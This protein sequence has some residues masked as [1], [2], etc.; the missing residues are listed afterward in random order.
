M[1][2]RKGE[3]GKLIIDRARKLGFETVAHN[4]SR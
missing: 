3:L 1:T 4:N 2:F